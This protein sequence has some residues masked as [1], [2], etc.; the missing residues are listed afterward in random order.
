M[1]SPPPLLSN[2]VCVCV[3]FYANVVDKN[4]TGDQPYILGTTNASLDSFNDAQQKAIKNGATRQ[5]IMKLSEQ[6]NQAAGLCTYY[7]AVTDTLKKQKDHAAALAQWRR[8]GKRATSQS[9]FYF[10]IIMT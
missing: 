4:S 5:E 2:C 7:D 8:L 9:L 10:F 3:F 6:W 1:T